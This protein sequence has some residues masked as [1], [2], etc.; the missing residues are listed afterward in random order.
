MGEWVLDKAGLA[1]VLERYDLY[2]SEKKV[3]KEHWNH[4]NGK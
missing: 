1:K 4:E 3:E 2:C